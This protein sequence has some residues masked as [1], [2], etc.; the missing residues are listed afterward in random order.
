MDKVDNITALKKL[1]EILGKDLKYNSKNS[2]NKLLSFENFI[3]KNNSTLKRN[4]EVYNLEDIYVYFDE[5]S[6]QY[7]VRQNIKILLVR[8]TYN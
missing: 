5:E 2:H 7:I 1:Y 4:N 8:S 6:N 3:R